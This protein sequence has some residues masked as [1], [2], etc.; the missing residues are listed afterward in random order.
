MQSR[1]SSAGRA[2]AS[3]FIMPFVRHNRDYKDHKNLNVYVNDSTHINPSDPNSMRDQGQARNAPY[4]IDSL[5]YHTMHNRADSEMGKTTYAQS[6]KGFPASTDERGSTAYV[7]GNVKNRD[8]TNLSF[9]RFGGRTPISKHVNSIDGL[10]KLNSTFNLIL[11]NKVNK[12]LAEYNESKKP[13]V[14]I[15]NKDP[16]VQVQDYTKNVSQQI[17]NP[18]YS[19]T[20][21]FF[22]QTQKAD[23]LHSFGYRFTNLEKKRERDQVLTLKKKLQKER[24]LRSSMVQ[25]V[26]QIKKTLNYVKSDFI[27]TPNHKPPT[28]PNKSR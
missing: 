3:N 11:S 2:T 25:E 6:W 10:P 27:G 28:H 12:R 4:N 13:V 8:V 21:N 14:N 1:Y 16:L 5:A 23:P 22:S 9:Y 24:D 7:S 19:T 15:I 18:G 20:T 26:E 17:F